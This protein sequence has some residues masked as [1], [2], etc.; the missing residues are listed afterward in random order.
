M[1][2]RRSNWVVSPKKIFL[3]DSIGAFVSAALLF[4]VLPYFE[5]ELGLPK[6]IFYT[7]FLFA[8]IFSIFSFICYRGV[9]K[10]WRKYLKIIS[11]ANFLYCILTLILLSLYH[12]SITILGLIYFIVEII[13][14]SCLAL[15]EF[16]VAK[17]EAVGTD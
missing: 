2:S 11:V 12:N 4:L 3:I 1:L 16:R 13:I 14:I 10:S 9:D 7:L 8:F 17:I 15:L 5:L 6:K